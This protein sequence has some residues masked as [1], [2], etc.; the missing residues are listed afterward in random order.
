MGFQFPTRWV[1]RSVSVS[2][3]ALAVLLAPQNSAASTDDATVGV[4]VMHGKGGSPTKHVIELATALEAA[5]YS[6]ANMDMPWSA[7]RDYNA[8]L[9]E[10]E[11][12]VDAAISAMKRRGVTKIFV[13]GHSQ[14][15]LFALLYGSRHPIQGVVAIAPGGDPSS[16]VPKE[17]LAMAVQLA[18]DLVSQG[19]AEV[20]AQLSDYEGAKGVTQVA[21]TPKIYLSW[22]DPDGDFTAMKALRGMPA[23]VPVLYIAPT[24]DYPALARL[25]QAQFNSLPR[26]PLTQLVEPRASHLHAPNASVGEI[27]KWIQAVDATP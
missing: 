5:G 17:K 22:F 6:V 12:E 7:K 19:K 18:R 1:I 23:T 3:F 25:K 15:G 2:V 24:D 11:A 4:I 21:T 20:V 13:A 9:G 8:S 26:N 16:K 10:A 27:L 14:G